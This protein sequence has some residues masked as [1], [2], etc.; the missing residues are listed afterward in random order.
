[1]MTGRRLDI[2]VAKNAGF[3]MGVRRALKLTLEAANTPSCPR[4][5]ATVGPLIHNRQVL[6]VLETKGVS[7]L[8][9]KSAVEGG[10][11]VV[12]AHGVSPS[13]HERLARMSRKLVDA[14]CPHVRNVQKIADKYC[15]E[16]YHC[17]IVGD[18]GHA[19]VEGVLAYTQGRGVV[20][21]GMADIE[22]LPPMEKVVI[23]AQTTQ[24]EQFFARVTEKLRARYPD[25]RVFDT[26]CRATHLRQVEAKRIAEQVELMIVVGG[27]HSANTRRLAQICEETG[28]PTMHVETDRELDMD[29]LLQC[30]RIGITAGASTP[31]WMIRRVIH[32]IRSE[33]D[34]RSRS[35]IHYLRLALAV[36]IRTNAFLGGGAAA[37]TYVSCRLMNVMPQNLW[38]CM[39][40]AF[41]FVLSQHLL[42]QYTKR[43]AMCLNEPDRGEFFQAHARALW[44]LGVA[45]SIVALVLAFV[46]G[47]ATFI[48]AAAGTL[49]GCL[50]CIPPERSSQ[51]L[52]RAP[53]LHRVP[54]SKEIFVG[55]AWAATT[56]LVPAI[57]AGALSRAFPGITVAMAFAFL[58]AFD[59]TLLTDLRDI[60]GDQLIGRETLALVLGDEGCKALLVACMALEAVVLVGGAVLGWTTPLG[61]LLLA[62]VA[63]AYACFVAFRQ[64]KLPEAELGESIVD[65][66]FYLCGLLAIAASLWPC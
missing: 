24:D 44:T 36:P 18:A 57:A 47:W 41:F 55:L 40:M 22:T 11:A 52:L 21:S 54:G 58:L 42:N 5:I 64:G 6:E 16:G 63:W 9:E 29:R 56:V 31:R 39:G 30:S 3:C 2:V 46:L 37:M 35:P 25:C 4:P 19:E 20:V 32:R 49:A 28:T 51:K 27:L 12:R 8:D 59:R 53:A 23:V 62:P 50:Y 7:I 14:T 17:I 33:H 60:E 48:I 34:R 43:D 1:M 13:D 38:A 26:I 45:C 66:K 61:Y 15:R 10:T 65:A